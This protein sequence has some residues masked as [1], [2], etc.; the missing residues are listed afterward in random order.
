MEY[1]QEM[2]REKGESR[3]RCKGVR[4]RDREKCTEKNRK[5]HARRNKGRQVS[6]Q[7]ERQTD[8]QKQMLLPVG[9]LRIRVSYAVNKKQRE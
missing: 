9:Y 5:K 7:T 1:L 4:K 2:K 3:E 8:G 6:R